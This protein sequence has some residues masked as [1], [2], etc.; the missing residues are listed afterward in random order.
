MLL[1]LLKQI[2]WVLGDSLRWNFK[3]RREKYNKFTYCYVLMKQDQWRVFLTGKVF[4][5]KSFTF[6]APTWKLKETLS[7]KSHNNQYSNYSNL[8]SG[9][10]QPGLNNNI[11]YMGRGDEVLWM[12]G[13]WN[14][15]FTPKGGAA[16]SCQSIPSGK[17]CLQSLRL[18]TS[19]HAVLILI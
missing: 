7:T 18:C 19:H 1:L 12:C 17:R 5:A 8:Q 15:T 11:K 16:C 10:Q 4:M 2:I 9:S 13:Y 14:C 3:P 6:S